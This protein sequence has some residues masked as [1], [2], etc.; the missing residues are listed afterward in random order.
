M[1]GF[2]QDLRFAIRSLVKN[3]GFSVIAIL[4]LALGIGINA[5]V[6]TLVNGVLIKGLPYEDSDRIFFIFLTATA[7]V[8]QTF[9][10]SYPEYE[11]LSKRVSSFEELAA[12]DTDQVA[13]NDAAGPETALITR[14][15][16]SLLALLGSQPVE[17]STL[18]PEEADSSVLVSYAL[19]QR[20]YGGREAL[21]STLKINGQPHTVAGIMPPG[22]GFPDD[23]DLWILGTPSSD[24]SHR[25]WAA[26]GKLKRSV[27]REQAQ[28]ELST[29][30]NHFRKLNPE[31]FDEKRILVQTASEVFN[32][33]EIRLVFLTALG[34]VGFVLLIACANVA[35]LLLARAVSRQHEI[36]IRNALGAS[37]WRIIRQMLVES[38]L[39]AIVGAALALPFAHLGVTVFD[40]LTAQVGRPGWI[41][42]SM[43]L[44]VFL[45]ILGLCALTTVIF[46]LAPAVR[47]SRPNLLVTLQ[48]GGRGASPSRGTRRLTGVLVA[49]QV[50]LALIL[51]VGAGLLIRSFVNSRT[52]DPGFPTQHLLTARLSL[53]ETS[54]EAPET[55]LRFAEEVL[56]RFSAQPD[57]DSV[58]ISSSL[59][60]RS[61]S[62]QPIR[63]QGQESAKQADLPITLL[64]NV[65]SDYLKTLKVPLLAGRDFSRNDGTPGMRHVLVNHKFADQFFPGEDVLGKRVQI[66]AEGEKEWATVVG[67]VPTL[68]QQF[69]NGVDLPT[70]YQPYRQ[71]PSRHFYLLLRSKAE[72]ESLSSR[73]R[74]LIQNIE[75][76]LPVNDVASMEERI[77]TMAWPYRIF[78]GLFASF[79]LIALFLSS[80]GI[81]GIM[82]HVV[83]QR[84][85]E[86]AIRMA[87]GARR[88]GVI[89]LILRQ[90]SLLIGIGLAVGLAGAFAL[91]RV[92]GS[93]LLDLSASDPVTFIAITFVIGSV[94]VGTILLPAQRATK[95]DPAVSLRAS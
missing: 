93:I 23:S 48:E 31:D 63:V 54:Y 10:F 41:D 19:W 13:I 27:S 77:S 4:A 55:Q 69:S 15:T 9:E 47:A 62:W 56:R 83:N 38:L 32:G 12:F 53:L 76:D 52:L 72:A 43:D 75:A 28:V 7:D 91:S 24:P 3:P 50:G 87:M 46:G 94:S 89:G 45:Y 14:M 79:A 74:Q 92:L 61:G 34:A 21:G 80:V 17:G 81:Y 51:L 68:R 18:R 71:E 95:I 86:F 90:G 44:T 1:N 20:R 82:S 26:I 85:K 49:G 6:F 59:P 60:L 37:R 64:V 73:V 30:T 33:G 22:F 88:S 36:S 11:E 84:K 29:L 65:S 42:F 2:F 35:N 40:Q 78:G 8:N 67:L 5:A 70:L 39:L 57:V 16:P 58:A 25:E 66:A